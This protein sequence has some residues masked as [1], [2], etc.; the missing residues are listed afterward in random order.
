MPLADG[1][2]EERYSFESDIIINDTVFTS[3]ADISRGGMYIKTTTVLKSG[4]IA[5]VSI[6][7]YDLEIDAEVRFSKPKEGTGLRFI[8]N[9]EE[10]RRKVDNIIA[11]LK[12]KAGD[13]AV[14]PRILL[15]EPQGILRKKL[16]L[17][18]VD[19]GFSV[20]E[21]ADGMEAVKQM[22]NFPFHAVVMETHLKKIGGLELIDMVRTAPDHKEKLII[23]MSMD[24]NEFDVDQT[25]DAGADHFV[26]KSDK[27]ADELLQRL[28]SRLGSTAHHKKEEPEEEGDEWE[29]KIV[30][31]PWSNED[32]RGQESRPP[33][34][35]DDMPPPEPKRKASDDDD[36]WGN[37]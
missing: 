26:Q 27:L 20:A 29:S 15:V 23:A 25:L 37:L 14:K 3:A 8:F 17:R 24:A 32:V 21:A 31:D 36:P 1:R 30:R 12:D 33:I 28:W 18:F 7:D 11:V 19:E 22:N 4:S 9:T 13:L 16:R 34:E 2:Q 5:S 10:E 6:P 35:H